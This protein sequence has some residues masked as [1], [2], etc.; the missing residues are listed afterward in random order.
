[1]RSLLGLILATPLAAGCGDNGEKPKPSD[2]G[3][4]TSAP[5]FNAGGLDD[6]GSDDG[7]S[8]D[9]GSDDGGSDDTGTESTLVEMENGRQDLMHDGMNRKYWLYQPD[10]IAEDAPLVLVMH[11]YGGNAR[12][13]Q[14]YSRMND[15]AD[16]HGFVV[17]YPQGTRDDDSSRFFNVGYAFHPGVTVDDVG[18][19][20]SIVTQL[21]S[22]L[23]VSEEN[24]FATGMS[25]GGEMSYMLACQAADVF[26]SVA[27]VS[28]IM[29]ESFASGCTPARPISIFEIHGTDDSVNWYAG[30]LTS[31]GGW[32]PYRGIEE[33]IAFWTATNEL[34]QQESA[35]L[36]DTDRSDGSDIT[37]ERHWS[38]GSDIEV[39]LYRVNGGGHD[40]PGDGGNM[41]IN[42]SE[43]VWS[44]FGRNL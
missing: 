11:G 1:M 33:G 37:F 22:N 19:V 17:A 25:N 21:Q 29:F 34:N 18:F 32:G 6:G 8:D 4:E 14:T 35:S 28:G 40:W 42:S 9:S 13:I 26:K 5:V 12:D 16:E 43:S 31:E 44:F 23:G 27:S 10:G 7:G 30:D 24:V 15:V 20:K 38:D 39:W 3:T 36:P 41:D 2:T